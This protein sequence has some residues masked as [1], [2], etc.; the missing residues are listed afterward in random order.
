MYPSGAWRGYWDQPYCGRQLMTPLILRFHEGRIE[1]EGRDMIGPFTFAGEY[2]DGGAIRMVKQYLGRHQVLYQ[3]S[4]DGE[5]TIFGQWSIPPLWSGSFAL[6]P[7]R[8]RP[9]TDIP[10]ENL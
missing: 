1:G 3:G 6:T 2:D 5:G 8:G 9:S 10:I 4:Y 7:I